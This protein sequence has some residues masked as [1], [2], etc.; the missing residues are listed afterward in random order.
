MSFRI[1]LGAALLAVAV[2]VTAAGDDLM[3][4][5]FSA[6]DLQNWQSKSFKGETRYTVVE[7]NGRRALFADSQGTASGLYR[8]I[9]VDLN[10]TPYLNWSWRVDRVLNGVDERSKAGDDYPARVYVAVSG[11]AAF[12]KTRSLVYVWSSNQPVGATWNN[13][14]TSNAQVMA[15]RSGTKDAGRWVSEKR[16][17]RADFRQLFGEDIEHIDAVALMTDTDN[18]GQRATAWYGDLYFT[19]R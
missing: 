1:L 17:I 14:F 12:W 15:L 3:I 9:R 13:A 19:A 4:G 16:D 8:E 7:Q 6:G 10:R 2:T 5:H 18:S 11:G